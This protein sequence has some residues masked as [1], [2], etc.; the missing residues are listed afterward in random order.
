MRNTLSQ[1]LNLSLEEAST[2]NKEVEC[3]F[4]FYAKLSDPSVL[5]KA[6][7][8][9]EHYQIEVKIKPDDTAPSG[10]RMRIRK[11]TSESGQVEYV[12]TIKIDSTPDGGARQSLEVATQSCEDAFS[13]LNGYATYGMHKRR[14]VIPLEMANPRSW[15]WEV[16][17]FID[18]EGKESDWCKID[19]EV[20]VGTQLSD[21]PDL[22]AGF[23]DVI[24]NQKGS[25]TP[26]EKLTIMQLYDTTFRLKPKPTVEPSVN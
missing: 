26:E 19:I 7:K 13:L 21:I 3:E 8:T 5:R 9:E 14:Y 25:N 23:S 12:Q 16:D 20:P 2:G 18:A 22:P 6:I 4:V 17:R 24:R 1:L 10:A 11:T 15:N